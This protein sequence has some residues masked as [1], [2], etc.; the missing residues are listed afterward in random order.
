MTIRP[1]LI[2]ALWA[3]AGG[4]A[5]AQ[6]PTFGLFQKLCVDTHAAPAAALAAAKA[7]GFVVPLA[8]I[9]RDLATLQL[10]ESQSRARL[11][12]GGI[13]IMVVGHKPFPAG[14]AMTMAGCA[15]VI[16]PAD[17]PS[18]DSLAAWAGVAPAQGGDGQPYF[19]FTGDPAHRRPALDAAPDDLTASAK[20]GDLQ[21]AGASHKPDVSVLIYGLV[22]P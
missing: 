8:S 14:A 13:L 22:Q 2:L 10:Q 9:T 21:I 7:E 6:T 19:L 3:L 4:T 17:G 18:E 20:A 11:V 15:L 12:D 16:V 1:G 5:L